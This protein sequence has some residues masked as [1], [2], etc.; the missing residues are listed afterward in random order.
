MD[1]T[2][3]ASF[4]YYMAH[5]KCRR[6]MALHLLSLPGLTGRGWIVGA[7]ADNG[8][9]E[10]YALEMNAVIS[11]F[12]ALKDDRLGKMRDDMMYSKK[13]KKSRTHTSA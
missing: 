9:A 11:N 2:L 5:S 3:A 13:K 10:G 6:P 7:I 1:S 8:N 4:N 12:G